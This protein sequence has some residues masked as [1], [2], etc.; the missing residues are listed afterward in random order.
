MP[1]SAKDLAIRDQEKETAARAAVELVQPGEIVGLGSGST[2]AYAIRFLAE[3]VR[4]GL[5]IVGIPTSQ[6]TKELAEQVG[7]P[8]TTLEEH[9]RIDIDIDGADEIGP[10][11]NLIKGGGGA[12]LREKIIASVSR[13]FIV[14][15]DSAKQVQRLGKFPLPVEVIAFAQSLIKPQIEALG[16]QVKL[17]EYA[18]G[19]PYVTDEGHH[20]LDCTFGEISDP[21]ELA[22]R[23]R[24][25]PGVVEHGLFI[26]MAEMAVIGR[27]G[28]TVLIRKQS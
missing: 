1:S 8:L 21:P 11:L 26:G 28:Q 2:A 6:K 10:Q 12:F 24:S 7:I 27:N 13:R 19:N 20:I 17:R 15:A 4:S 23:L 14:I 18:Y 22:Q 16:A 3:R 5:K 9:P 25:I